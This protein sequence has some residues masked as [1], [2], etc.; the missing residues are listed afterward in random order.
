[1]DD[2]EEL[3]SEIEDLRSQLAMI[4]ERKLRWLNEI[5]PIMLRV[6]ALERKLDDIAAALVKAGI[7]I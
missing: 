3:R 6:G 1:M 7:A 5:D 4:D 2:L